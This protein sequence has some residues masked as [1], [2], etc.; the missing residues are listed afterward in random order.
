MN[1]MVILKQLN[2]T[3]IDPKKLIKYEKGHFDFLWSR[4]F[5]L[6]ESMFTKWFSTEA[7]TVSSFK[8]L[9]L[10][11][12]AIWKPDTHQHITARPSPPNCFWL[13]GRGQQASI[14]KSLFDMFLTIKTVL[15]KRLWARSDRGLHLWGL[16]PQEYSVFNVKSMLCF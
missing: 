6:Q 4:L 3:W 14:T 10:N 7:L 2:N 9:N 15:T 12:A 11:M 8:R 1:K 16:T 5:L 13:S